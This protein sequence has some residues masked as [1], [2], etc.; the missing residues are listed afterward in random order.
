MSII[1]GF[2]KIFK[3]EENSENDFKKLKATR[4]EERKL[5]MRTENNSSL[6]HAKDVENAIVREYRDFL[7]RKITLSMFLESLESLNDKIKEDSILAKSNR[8]PSVFYNIFTGS[9]DLKIQRIIAEIIFEQ[10]K[11]G[12]SDAI[13][14]AKML[15][16]LEKEHKTKELLNNAA[17]RILDF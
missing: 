1:S 7:S 17:N 11:Q 2:K 14:V 8:L 15:S 10:A 5:T 16:Q 6:E 13:R 4:A 3:K 12:N 9:G